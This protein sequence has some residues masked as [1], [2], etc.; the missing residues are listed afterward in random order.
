MPLS[1]GDTTK[2]LVDVRFT[3]DVN[4]LLKIEAQVVGTDDVQRLM[5]QELDT[6]M[7]EAAV[8]IRLAALASIKLHPRETMAHRAL[9]ARGDH[10]NH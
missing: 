3:Y 7:P 2:C 10:E 8:A 9:L 4:G 5:L 6:D 1:P